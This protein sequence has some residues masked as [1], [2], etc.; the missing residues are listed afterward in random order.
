MMTQNKTALARSI[1]NQLIAAKALLESIREIHARQI[2]FE[3]E[4]H[5]EM[6]IKNLKIVLGEEKPEECSKDLVIRS[7]QLLKN[8]DELLGA[9]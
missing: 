9:A 6:A 7:E 4:C 2:D 5:L 3:G 8:I 1:Q